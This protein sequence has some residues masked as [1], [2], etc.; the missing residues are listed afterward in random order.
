[1]IWIG[2]PRPIDWKQSEIIWINPYD[3]VEFFF[4]PFPLSS[5]P[6]PSPP[7]RLFKWI[8]LICWDG[9]EGAGGEREQRIDLERE[10]GVRI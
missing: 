8:Y 6:L 9:R 3:F 2:G 4:L 5:P 10:E 1:M 7:L